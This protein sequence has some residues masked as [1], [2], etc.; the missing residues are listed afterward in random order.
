MAKYP[1]YA[2][3]ASVGTLSRLTHSR[4]GQGSPVPVS[5]HD[6]ALRLAIRASLIPFGFAARVVY[7]QVKCSSK[8]EYLT[9]MI[10]VEGR[11]RTME[12]LT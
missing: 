1:L 9:S 5:T 6:A 2:Q 11:S 8:T 4:R 3:N 12:G 10:N 7:P